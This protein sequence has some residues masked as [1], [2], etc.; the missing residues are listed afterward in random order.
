[1]VSKGAA[2]CVDSS[3]KENVFLAT[4]EPEKVSDI[5]AENGVLS[6]CNNRGKPN[7]IKGFKDQGSGQEREACR[8]EMQLDFRDALRLRL[9]QSSHAATGN[10][11]TD[12]RAT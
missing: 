2:F 12:S 10:L 8:A 4:S 11:Q 3:S 1:M 7:K 9:G 5:V 6:N